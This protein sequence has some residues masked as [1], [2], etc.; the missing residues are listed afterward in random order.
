M[1]MVEFAIL[2]AWKNR[3]SSN[4]IFPHGACSLVAFDDL[5]RRVLNSILKLVVIVRR[6]CH[7]LDRALSF[8]MVILYFRQLEMWLLTRLK[9]EHVGFADIDIDICEIQFEIL[10]LPT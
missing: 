5:R 7:C 10:L 2:P 9:Q 4:V 3:I 6:M 1:Q 8:F